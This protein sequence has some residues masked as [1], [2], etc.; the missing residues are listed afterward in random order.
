MKRC[1]ALLL[2]LCLVATAFP[3]QAEAAQ[4]GKLIALTFD[5]GPDSTDTVRLLDGLAQRGVKVTFFVQGS[6]AQRNLDIITRA[7][8]EGHELANHSWDHP[9]LT[10]QSSE[11][12]ASQ[13]SQTNAVL[14]LVCGA[15]TKYL[16]RPP[17]GSV[18][19]RVI[20]VINAPMICWSVDP[21][22]W[23]YFNPYT[24][25]DNILYGAYDGAII[26]VHDIHSTSVDGALLAV[27]QLLA[28]GYE[29]VTVSELY[30]RR[31]VSLQDCTWYYDCKPTGVDYGAIPTPQITYTT[32]GAAMTVTIT[33]GSDAPV[34]YTTDGSVPNYTS[35]VYT[36]PFTVPYPTSI[37]AVAAYDLNGSR[38]A[39][40][41]LIFGVTPCSAPDI[42]S[43]DGQLVLSC[44][45]VD[46]GIYYTFDGNDPRYYGTA[47]TGPI[48]VP[49]NTVIRA[50]A[51]GGFYAMSAETAYYCSTRGNLYTDVSHMAWYFEPIDRVVSAG[52]MNGVGGYS[53]APNT[54]LTRA[55][56]VTLLYR[57]CGGSLGEGWTRTYT[58]QDVPEGQWYTE[59]IEWAYR[60]QIV[61]GYSAAEF[62]PD[63][64]VTRQELCKVIH[65]FLNYRGNP[66]PAGSSCAGVFADYS[67]I[68]VWALPS[69]EAMVS[70]GLIQ[71]DGTNVNPQGT[72]TRAEVAKILCN[73]MDYEGY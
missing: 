52:L 58:F 38:S 10:S 35:P 13:M 30:R 28:Q 65:Y 6:S 33:A 69:V 41:D 73:L 15:G 8:N 61:N 44:A 4:G 63:G 71:G 59:A 17:Y 3:I 21:Y 72:A 56:L 27:D 37:R 32:D 29:F 25:R 42:T 18:N 7:Y 36:E 68:Q 23:K 1:I 40:A 49:Y 16:V 43:Q 45:Q 34:Y 19:D 51:G 70:A 64:Y 50:V 39:T 54:Q 62:R 55:M 20:Q 9:E 26:L 48:A 31:G 57:Y 46:A 60:N 47:Y 66:L 24:V 22:D 53:F 5:D 14:D 67:A 11:V 2:V 12:V